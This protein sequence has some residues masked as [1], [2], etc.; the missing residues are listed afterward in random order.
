MAM[1]MN[2]K[3]L[4]YHAV[5]VALALLIAMIAVSAPSAGRALTRKVISIRPTPNGLAQV[6][7]TKAPQD[8]DQLGPAAAAGRTAGLSLSFH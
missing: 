1:E 6:T 7:V 5:P 8:N 4:K 2:S 3:N